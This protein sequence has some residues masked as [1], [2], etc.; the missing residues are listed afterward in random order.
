M[1]EN[2]TETMKLFTLENELEVY[3]YIVCLRCGKIMLTVDCTQ[4]CG[5]I[6]QHRLQTQT[7]LFKFNQDSASLLI[8]AE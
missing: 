4:D 3:A 5:I 1:I 2:I 6:I 7:S 8:L